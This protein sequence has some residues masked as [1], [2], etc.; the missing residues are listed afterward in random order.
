MK[1]HLKVKV[2][3]M[4]AEM[5]YIR[6]QEE[7]W[8]VKAKLAK[9]KA[10]FLN[11]ELDKATKYVD[12]AGY[13]AVNFWTLR[14]HRKELKREIRSSH[15]AY[16]CMKGTPYSAMEQICYGPLKG[17]NTEEPNWTSIIETV[18]RFSKDEPNKTEIMQRASQWM[19]DAQTWYE[20][21]SA[22]IAKIRDQ[23]II[24]YSKMV[25][26]EAYQFDLLVWRKEAAKLAKAN[27]KIP[28]KPR[29]KKAM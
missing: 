8:K 22:R 16:G 17:Y 1:S 2:V 29:Y 7:K 12:K 24:A 20:G 15:L 5:T 6:R 21:N 13:A 18:E 10:E 4:S 28:P 19:S 9:A 23:R 3:S 27:L 11:Q 25:H 14:Y 26:D